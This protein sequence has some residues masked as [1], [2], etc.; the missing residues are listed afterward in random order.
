MSWKETRSLI[1]K[2]LKRLTKSHA[3]GVI[4]RYL[5]TN[6][7][8]KITFW[9]RIGNYLKGKKGIWKILYLI[10]FLIHKHNMYKTGIQLPF[11]AKVGGGLTFAHFSCIIINHNAVIGENCTI[12]Q[13]VTIGGTR[14]KGAPVVGDNVVIF[15][16]AKLVSGVAIGN[17]VVIGANAV[18]ISDVPSHVTIGGIPAKVISNKADKLIEQYI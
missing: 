16:G 6:A 7:S 10:V 4:L 14:G 11:G 2:D 12:F 8:F 13:G 15:A 3:G 1:L 18:V 17:N 5:F 9:F